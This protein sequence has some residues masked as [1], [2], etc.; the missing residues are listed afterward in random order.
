MEVKRYRLTLAFI[1]ILIII[2]SIFAIY[3]AKK[4]NNLKENIYTGA[5]EYMYYLK[6]Y[7][8]QIGIYR[9][10]EE[11]PF[12]VIEVYTFNLPSVDQYELENG[13]YVQD[14]EK[15][16]MIIEDYES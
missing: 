14:D 7:N 5:S 1:V 4:N 13:I 2:V 12:R 3:Y 9:A 16:Q 15:L 10:N 11:N 6:E 8:D